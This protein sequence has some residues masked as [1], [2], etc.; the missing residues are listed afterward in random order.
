MFCFAADENAV[1][2]HAQERH[3]ADDRRSLN[4]YLSSTGRSTEEM[5]GENT[6]K[7]PNSVLRL[8]LDFL[9]HHLNFLVPCIGR[10]VQEACKQPTEQRE[11]NLGI[12]LQLGCVNAY[13]LDTYPPIN[14]CLF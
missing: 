4:E 5:V 7:R 3:T 8:S 12:L 6:E 1:S 10:D 2:C 13:P 9:K 14:V 11:E